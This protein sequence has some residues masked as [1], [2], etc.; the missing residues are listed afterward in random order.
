[1]VGILCWDSVRVYLLLRF[2]C[3]FLFILNIFN[4][5]IILRV[6][7]E[8]IDYHDLIAYFPK[9]SFKI[10]SIILFKFYISFPVISV[11]FMNSLKILNHFSLAYLLFRHFISYF[12]CNWSNSP[13]YLLAFYSVSKQ[14]TS[15]L[16]ILLLI[17]VSIRF[18]YYSFI[19]HFCYFYLRMRS[20]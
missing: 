17:C 15:K 18:S 20:S 1:M 11:Y 7:K 5:Y 8:T 14:L 19:N 4:D 10:S 9:H 12:P 6:S 13:L 16:F 2:L 3:E